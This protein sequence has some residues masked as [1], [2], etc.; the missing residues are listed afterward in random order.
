MSLLKRHETDGERS[1]GKLIARLHAW[2]EG[3]EAVPEDAAE[4]DIEG[5]DPDATDAAPEMPSSR[6]RRASS[7][8]R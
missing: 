2:W 6:I 8:A 3:Y 7:S 5:D 4:P 1:G